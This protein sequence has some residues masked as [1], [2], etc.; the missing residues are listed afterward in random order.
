[1]DRNADLAEAVGEIISPGLRA[2]R[3]RTKE[4]GP[5]MCSRLARRSAGALMINVFKVIM[6]CDFALTALSLATFRCRIISEVPPWLL[7]IAVA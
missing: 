2:A 4:I 3:C 1:M 6:A 5:R 7:A